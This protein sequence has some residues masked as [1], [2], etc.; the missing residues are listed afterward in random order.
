MKRAVVFS[1]VVGA[2]LVGGSVPVTGLLDG[3]PVITGQA[4]RYALGG[5]LLLGWAKVRR[6]PLPRPRLVDVPTLFGLAATGMIGFQACLLLAQRYAEPSAVA[7]FLGASPLVLALVAP[8]LDGRRPS[9]APVVG[10]VLAGLGIVLLSGGGSASPAGLALAALAMLCEASFTLLAVGLLRRLGPLATSMWSCF[11]AA[12]GGAIVGTVA[13]P[14]GA[15]RLPDAREL[16]ALLVLAV[17]VT[18]VAFVL[19]YSC[20]VGLGADRA[21]VLIGLMPVSGLVVAV[22]IGAQQFAVV[23]LVGVALVA[24]GVACGLRP[25]TPAHAAADGSAEAERVAVP[26]ECAATVP[27]VPVATAPE[28]PVATVLPTPA[29]TALQTPVATALQ[30]PVATALQTPVAAA[31]GAAAPATERPRAAAAPEER[32]ATAPQTP[33]AAPQAPVAA[34][35]TPVAPVAQRLVAPVAERSAAPA[36]QTPMAPAPERP[37]A[38]LPDTPLT[39]P[40]DMSVKGTMTESHSP[41]VAFTDHRAR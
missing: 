24:A 6:S 34:A 25:V 38:A 7:A 23:D 8:L 35:Q 18:A 5:L 11:A 15:W 30:V 40:S 1:G 31:Q 41:M 36:P 32:K 27:E 39:A 20:V 13:D 10:A 22:L 2:V 21:G 33:V 19:W 28:V 4:L 14:G 16:V 37:I 3:Y 26:E 9:T 17:L 29:A 12:G